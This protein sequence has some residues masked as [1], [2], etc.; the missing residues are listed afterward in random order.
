MTKLL[1]RRPGGALP[2][3][4]RPLAPDVVGERLDDVHRAARRRGDRR[5][6]GRRRAGGPTG[7]WARS[8]DEDG[9]ATRTSVGRDATGR[10]WFAHGWSSGRLLGPLVSLIRRSRSARRRHRGR[11]T[12]RARAGRSRRPA[13]RRSRTSRTT[14]T[15]ATARRRRPARAAS[16]AGG[17]RPRPSTRRRPTGRTPAKAAATSSAAS[18]MATTARIRRRRSASGAE[19]EAL[20]AAAG[21]EHDRVEPADRGR[22]WRGARWPWSRRTSARRRP[23]P[24]A[25]PGG[26]GR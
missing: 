7:R 25:R 9:G 24:P 2:S 12:A 6:L 14:R 16:A 22:R 13:R 10:R 5:Q 18:P 26:P 15:P 1:E 17:R 11:P 19:V 3:R 21:D 20:V 4:R 8:T 23:R